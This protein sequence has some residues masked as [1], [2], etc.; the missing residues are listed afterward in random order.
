MAEPRDRARHRKAAAAAAA[1]HKA[2]TSTLVRLKIDQSKNS[3]FTIRE[4]SVVGPE[5]LFMELK[6]DQGTIFRLITSS[7]VF[8]NNTLDYCVSVCGSDEDYY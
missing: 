1:D 4:R 7:S 2:L 6:S 5:I 8:K 3:L